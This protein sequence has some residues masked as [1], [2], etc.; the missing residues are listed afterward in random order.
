MMH[1]LRELI[2]NLGFTAALAMSLCIVCLAWL[3]VTDRRL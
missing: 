2:H 1:L 3:V